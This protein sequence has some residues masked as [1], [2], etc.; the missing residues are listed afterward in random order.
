MRSILPFV[1][2]TITTVSA[3]NFEETGETDDDSIVETLIQDLVKERTSSGRA[4]DC[5]VEHIDLR[6]GQTGE[7]LLLVAFNCKYIFDP[8]L[9]TITSPNYPS[10][11]SPSSKCIYWLK[12]EPQTRIHLH[13]DDIQT[14]PCNP[15]F[16]DFV[17]LSPDWDWKSFKMVCG[18]TNV[19][20]PIDLYSTKTE[21]AIYLRTSLKYRLG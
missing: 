20:L 16:Y 1:I 15:K 7:Y 19:K 18:T 2:W 14:Q 21:A 8:I 17:L 11:Y 4:F 6:L 9:G 12:S 5:G 10:N 3:I 13:C